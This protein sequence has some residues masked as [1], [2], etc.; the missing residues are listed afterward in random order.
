MLGVVYAPNTM[1]GKNSKRE[2]LVDSEINE[3][4]LASDCRLFGES[5][6]AFAGGYRELRCVATSAGGLG[7][8]GSLS[9]S[10]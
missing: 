4:S 3:G 5:P 8:L 10:R 6:S 2:S 1:F 9:R 7:D